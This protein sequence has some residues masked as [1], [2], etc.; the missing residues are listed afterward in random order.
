MKEE[1]EEQIEIEEEEKRKWHLF[2]EALITG[3]DAEAP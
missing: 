2:F 1:K 3:V